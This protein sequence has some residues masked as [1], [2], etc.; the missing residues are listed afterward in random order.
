VTASAD[1]IS[2]AAQTSAMLRL[3]GSTDAEHLDI[4]GGHVGLMVGGRARHQSW[5]QLEAWLATRSD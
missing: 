4:K 1:H 3:A 2:P 5:P